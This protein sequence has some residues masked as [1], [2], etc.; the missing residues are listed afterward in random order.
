MTLQLSVLDVSPVS[1]GSTPADAL[2]NSLDLAQL[3]D[4]LGYVRYWFAEHHNMAAIA[5]SS[6]EVMIGHAAARTTRMRIGSGGV[7]LPNHSPLH[8]AEMFRAL[9]ALHPGRI[10]L[11]VGRAPGTDMLTAVALRGSA[12]ALGA[13]DFP[14]QLADL[15]GFLGDGFADDHPFRRIDAMPETGGSP[16]VWLLGSS[17]FSA[18]LAAARGLPFGFAH[19]I[20][21]LPAVP[22]L[23]AYRDSFAASPRAAR[24]TALLATSVVCAETD[25]RAEELASSSNL[26]WLRLAQG[27]ITP[28]PSVEEALAYRYAP[29]E[30][31]QVRMRPGHRVVGS[32]ETVRR[33]LAALAADAGVDELMIM[34]NVHNHGERRR[35]YE[36]LAE[37]FALESARAGR[38][39]STTR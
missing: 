19:H 16:P 14:D 5:S 31:E 18:R 33:A 34:T 6:P 1:S 8:V 23:R 28:L 32:P 13:D 27:R 38:E 26:A 17:M 20:D 12:Q 21:P 22:A 15:L 11:G 9:E 35:S 7:M 3:C 10:D 39:P 4:A 24:P 2:R 29:A 37:E 36:L 25:A 30:L